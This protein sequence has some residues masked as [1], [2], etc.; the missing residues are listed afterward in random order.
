MPRDKKVLIARLAVAAGLVLAL[1]VAIGF[2]IANDGNSPS[3]S[4]RS[5]TSQS[6]LGL[7]IS[8]QTGQL[9]VASVETGGPADEASIKAG[10]IIRSVDGQVVRTPN[11]L[12]G[13]IESLEPG[14]QVSITY[15]RGDA[16]I[17]A[18]VRLG[19]APEGYQIE[20]ESETR[21]SGERPAT[22][23]ADGLLGV[24]RQRIQELIESSDLSPAEIERA[25]QSPAD[26]LQ[27]GT[28]IEASSRS[29]TIVTF[30]GEEFRISLTEDTSI[31]RQGD[32]ISAEELQNDEAVMVLSLDGGET[33]HGVYTFGRLPTTPEP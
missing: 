11:Q 18:Q 2:L 14:E 24:L 8:A 22:D 17:Q 3:T 19:D 31:I 32:K 21:R 33:A 30:A 9:R 28:V 5:A 16:E 7:T 10:D 29:L 23:L 27:V 13:A 20:A 25:I 4:S 26:S 1:G 15:E 12:R 6:Y